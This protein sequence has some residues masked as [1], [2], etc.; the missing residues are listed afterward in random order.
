MEDDNLN[1]DQLRRQRT[2][3]I[4]NLPDFVFDTNIAAP[5]M[6]KMLEREMTDQAKVTPNIAAVAVCITSSNQAWKK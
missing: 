5:Q 2:I 4:S 6:T 3:Q 1:R